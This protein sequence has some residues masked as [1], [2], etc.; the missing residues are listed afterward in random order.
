MRCMLHKVHSD[1]AQTTL[2]CNGQHNR[3]TIGFTSKSQQP[4]THK[5]MD[6][7]DRCKVRFTSASVIILA[8]QYGQ[9]TTWLF[10]ASQDF[11]QLPWK[12]W[13]HDFVS[14]TFSPKAKSCKHIEHIAPSLSTDNASCVAS[15]SLSSGLSQ[16][17][18]LFLVSWQFQAK[19]SC[20]VTTC[21][22]KVP[23]S[24]H[25]L[26]SSDEWILSTTVTNSPYLSVPIQS[27]SSFPVLSVWARV[28]W[29]PPSQSLN[30]LRPLAVPHRL[31][32]TLVIDKRGT[33]HSKSFEWSFVPMPCLSKYKHQCK[34]CNQSAESRVQSTVQKLPPQ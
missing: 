25:V 29:H 15:L 21:E 9:Q 14:E 8:R 27:I 32:P 22:W 30:H 12:T 16:S 34:R 1:D 33:L 18:V 3:I 31:A 5:S 2:K 26:S 4:A 17:P 28:T 19:R 7:T 20:S 10:D 13:L 6:I 24:L 11:M 23:V